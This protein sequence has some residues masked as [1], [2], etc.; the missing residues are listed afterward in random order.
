MAKFS[1]FLLL[2]WVHFGGSRHPQLPFSYFQITCITVGLSLLFFIFAY[3]EYRK[4]KSKRF[5]FSFSGPALWL[6]LFFLWGAGSY[7]YTIRL[8]NS[9]LLITRYLGACV[10]LLGLTLYLTSQ[11][12]VYEVFWLISIN[13]GLMAL[14]GVLQPLNLPYIV[15][16]GVWFP[17]A[18]GLFINPNCFAG[19]IVV[20]LPIAFYLI[21]SSTHR[22]AKYA[23][24]AITA[25]L[26]SGLYYSQ[27]RGGQI[28]VCVELG[29]F[30]SYHV[31]RLQNG[32][33][34]R[35]AWGVSIF[36]LIFFLFGGAL[37][38][39]NFEQFD[40]FSHSLLQATP[41]IE[42]SFQKDI[43]KIDTAELENIKHQAE[44][45][46]FRDK[47][48]FWTGLG[49]R[50]VVWRT[51]W[52]IFKDRPLTGSG[53]WTF[54]ILLPQYLERY[55]IQKTPAH[56]QSEL[57]RV[58]HAH[59]IFVQTL[60]DYGIV[61]FALFFGAILC[62]VWRFVIQLKTKA[63]SSSA[64]LALIL[65]LIGF[66]AHNLIEY[67][68]PEPAF[69]YFFAIGV[70]CVDFLKGKK[71][72]AKKST[73][74]S[75]FSNRVLPVICGVIG[76]ATFWMAMN[77]FLYNKAIQFAL[78]KTD[79]LSAIKGLEKSRIFCQSCDLHLLY[80]ASIRIR[81]FDKRKG[82][83]VLAL[84][85]RDLQRASEQGERNEYY[86]V[87]LG[88]WALRSEDMKTA[89]TAFRQAAKYKTTRDRALVGL[90]KIH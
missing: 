47:V 9:F 53:A 19:Y 69:I 52:D 63:P 27:S 2:T 11:K 5:Q 45:G 50:M 58:V 38:S 54:R 76:L 72:E 64:E 43:S 17:Q 39:R 87:R 65:S 60:I 41:A 70:Y 36:I 33:K 16:T 13:S 20:H 29:F 74:V 25:L 68:W 82:A 23:A 18:T 35:T 75:S 81:E 88:D 85:G 57:R 14:I 12:K 51:A 1:L 59:N 56:I 24:L 46:P 22:L 34:K 6:A 40:K 4:D 61:G 30:A 83:R 62:I 37:Q 31:C 26:I 8:D 48:G 15:G 79:Y 80:S 10:F 21:F 77:Y 86:W 90:E 44:I 78:K 73:P 66:M 67:N 7:F 89:R 49:I 42:L 84:A 55:A 71:N 32:L 3:R 28:A